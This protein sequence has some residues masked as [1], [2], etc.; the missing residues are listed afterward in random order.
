MEHHLFLVHKLH[1]KYFT[2]NMANV[3]ARP[4]RSLCKDALRSAIVVNYKMHH[5]GR[6]RRKCAIGSIGAIESIVTCLNML[7]G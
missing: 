5:R 7:S 4:A 2:R 6:R 1:H 3:R